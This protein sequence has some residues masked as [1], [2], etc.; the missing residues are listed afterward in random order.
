MAASTST[1]SVPEAAARAVAC[2]RIHSW[3]VTLP[4]PADAAPFCHA[5]AAGQSHRA[6]AT[7]SAASPAWYREVDIPHLCYVV[8][9]LAVGAD[10]LRGRN[11]SVAGRGTTRVDVP[12]GCGEDTGLTPLALLAVLAVASAPGTKCLGS[13]RASR[14]FACKRCSRRAQ[15]RTHAAKRGASGAPRA[16][17]TAHQP[18]AILEPR[19]RRVRPRTRAGNPSGGSEL[20]AVTNIRRTWRGARRVPRRRAAGSGRA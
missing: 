13:R 19:R 11:S 6:S 9:R 16:R 20:Q 10:Q 15:R 18:R 14:C 12:A 2:V 8:M 1:Q 7:M 5:S 3:T 17:P 4:L